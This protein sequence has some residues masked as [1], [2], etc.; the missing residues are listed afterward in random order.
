LDFDFVFDDFVFAL[1]SSFDDDDDDDVFNFVGFSDFAVDLT[2]SPST[3]SS[4]RF[5]GAITRFQKKK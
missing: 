1:P 2:S 3:A 5:L 4:L